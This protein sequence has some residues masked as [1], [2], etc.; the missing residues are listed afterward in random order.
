LRT[1]YALDQ[2][3][4]T[5]LLPV[6]RFKVARPK[7]WKVLADT[8]AWDMIFPFNIYQDEL[9]DRY[10]TDKET[11]VQLDDPFTSGDITYA[12]ATSN[13]D[14]NK[15]INGGVSRYD[16]HFFW[17]CSVGNASKVI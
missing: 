15:W 12:S 5:V 3:A 17:A 9:N 14:S 13:E 16:Q 11:W 1:L 8:D 6:S 2:D 7:G 10:N 4:F